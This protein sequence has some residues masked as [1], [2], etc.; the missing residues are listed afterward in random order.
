MTVT[1]RQLSVLL[2][3]AEDWY[4]R[5]P[6]DWHAPHPH[7]DGCWVYNPDEVWT[8]QPH[9]CVTCGHLKAYGR[10]SDPAWPSA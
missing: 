5:N 6:C 3:D 1:S 9:V 10:P 2:G 7:D 8:P 4:H